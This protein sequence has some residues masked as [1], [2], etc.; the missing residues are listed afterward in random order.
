MLA[1]T[2]KNTFYT[3]KYS[4]ESCGKKTIESTK[5]KSKNICALPQRGLFSPTSGSTNDNLSELTKK[6]GSCITLKKSTTVN[7]AIQSSVIT[8][9]EQSKI[10]KIT[11]YTIGCQIGQGAYAV[12]KSGIHKSTGRKVAI[13]IYE[14]YKIAD[15]QRKSCVSREIRVLKKLSHEHIVQLFETID[16]SKQLFLVMEMVKGKSLYSYVHS[17]QNRKVEEQECMKLFG[18]IVSGIEYCHKNNVI[19]R[20]I[21]MENLLL[22]EHHNIKI[23]DF[24]FSICALASQKLKIFC[25][26][27]SYMAPEIV[28]KKEYSGPPA[29]M[30]SL[31]V[32]L[33]AMLCGVFPF[34]GATEPELFRC[35]Q[36]CH[37]TF[38]TH[39]SNSAKALVSRLLKFDPEKRATAAEVRRNIYFLDIQRSHNAKC[40]NCSAANEL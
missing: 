6:K 4:K 40:A 38:P 22:D 24:G 26:T 9:S 30:W 12:V 32:L 3:E 39:V 15:P 23:I 18:Q 21:K 36:R 20:D 2:A 7:Q 10:T 37:I 14:K 5:S 19:H 27:P 8:P 17:K 28:M 13:K 35:I 31:G 33:Y 16:T 25:G 34:K 11:D 1:T 29:D